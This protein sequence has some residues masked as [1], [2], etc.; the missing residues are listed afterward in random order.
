MV[1]ADQLAALVMH[2]KIITCPCV[3]KPLGDTRQIILQ[4]FF[5]GRG[6]LKLIVLSV[7]LTPA[8]VPE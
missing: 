4:L 1:V 2:R 8:T 7:P 6:T 5:D 3:G